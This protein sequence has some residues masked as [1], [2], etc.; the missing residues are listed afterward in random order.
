MNNET[1]PITVTSLI[2]KSSITLFYSIKVQ[3]H[4]AQ[5]P[6][7]ISPDN[8][9]HFYLKENRINPPWQFFD[10][11]SFIDIDI[12]KIMLYLVAIQDRTD[13]ASDSFT[14]PCFTK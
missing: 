4:V 12:V 2:F 3:V 7:I 13:F 8:T 1:I 5:V 9:L 10:I 6:R 11:F 14:Y